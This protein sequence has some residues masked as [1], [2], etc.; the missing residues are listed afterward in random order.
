MKTYALY[1]R[2]EYITSG[3]IRQ[4]AEKTGRKLTSLRFLATPAYKKRRSGGHP[5]VNLVCIGDTGK[6]REA[7]HR[8]EICGRDFTTPYAVQKYCSE[9]CKTMAKETKPKK[10]FAEMS[11]ADRTRK[12][13]VCGKE[14][15]ARVKTQK[16]CSHECCVKASHVLEAQRARKARETYRR[17]PKHKS[18]IVEINEQ[19]RAQGKSYGQL[20]AEKL[21]ARMHAE[22]TGGKA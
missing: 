20:Q 4:I 13:S 21:I 8:C 11:E 19:A 7:V 3:T 2:E 15:I 18:R 1:E 10:R 16:Y 9:A 14:Y 5:R 17:E 12:C 6:K 22:M